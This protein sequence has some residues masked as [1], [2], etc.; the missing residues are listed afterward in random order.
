MKADHDDESRA[1]GL[2]FTPLS[3]NKEPEGDSSTLTQR[4][5]ETEVLA[6]L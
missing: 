6:N 3:H 2:A 4:T 1:A 5:A